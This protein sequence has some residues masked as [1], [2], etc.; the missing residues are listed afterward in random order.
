MEGQGIL[1]AAL[2]GRMEGY[3]KGFHGLFGTPLWG[4]SAAMIPLSDR[5]PTHIT[6]ILTYLLIG[7]NLVMFAGQVFGPYGFEWSIAA[8]GFIPARLLGEVEGVAGAREA[9][10]T[11]FTS[12]FLHGS[13]MHIG[14]NMLYLWV[15]GDNIENDLGR[16]RFVVLYLLSG[17]VA[18]LAQMAVD[19]ASTI[20]MVGASGAISGVLGAYLILHPRQ[21]ITVLVPSF[22][23]TRMPAL[24]VLGMWF[25][26]QL[27]YGLVADAS[28]GG[29][30]FWAHI[31][32]FVAGVVLVKV[33]GKVR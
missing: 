1:R 17:L 9:W 2:I 11:L 21:P 27:L 12:M 32:G 28:G 7:M 15:F 22:G 18:A 4:Y 3:V 10:V 33:L 19:P 5:N 29:V 25:G 24:V 26:Y 6:P 8:M 16:G 20:P 30:A 13:L 14:G 23:I 31:G